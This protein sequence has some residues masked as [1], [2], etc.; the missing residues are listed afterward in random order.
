MFERIQNFVCEAI[1]YCDYAIESL[2]MQM[3]FLTSAG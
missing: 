1:D 2:H 3:I